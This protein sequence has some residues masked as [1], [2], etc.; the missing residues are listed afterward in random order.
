MP[1][2]VLLKATREPESSAGTQKATQARAGPS[3]HLVQPQPR[4]H[5]AQPILLQQLLHHRFLKRQ[6]QAR[7]RLPQCI[8]LEFGNR[9]GSSSCGG[10]VTA[11]ARL[12]DWRRCT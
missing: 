1:L 6:Q 12:P 5:H 11:G 2:K 7:S 9:L 3:P 8:R 4:A 10:A